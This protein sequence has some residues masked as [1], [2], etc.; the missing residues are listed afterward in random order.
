MPDGGWSFDHQS[1]ACNGRCGEPGLLG[2]S[3]I[4]ATSMALLPFLA[5]G[6]STDDGPYR[7]QIAGGLNF[8]MAAQKPDGSL[9]EPSGAFYSHAMATMAL[10]D[11]YELML[12]DEHGPISKA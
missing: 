2:D 4:A 7:R 10:C 9:W 8:L 6:Y 12:P 1:G 11:A 5:A 3:R